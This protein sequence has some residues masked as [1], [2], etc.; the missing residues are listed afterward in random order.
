[1]ESEM[2]ERYKLIFQEHQFA[3][4]F[5]RKIITG[6]CTIYMA[7]AIVF[8]W[9]NENF[10]TLNWL[11]T[12]VGI[13][14]TILMW[15]ADKRNRQAIGLSKEI[16]AKIEE[17]AGIDNKQQFFSRLNKGFSHST[18]ID[19]FAGVSVFLLLIATAY[20]ICNGGCLPKQQQYLKCILN[21]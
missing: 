19:I 12:T 7:L 2:L 1:M 14:V 11:V 4:E 5:R 18:A 3:S 10:C 20:L 17:A 21:Y 9:V 6:W 15:T 13:A 8:T 16:G